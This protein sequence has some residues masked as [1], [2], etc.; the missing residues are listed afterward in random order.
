MTRGLIVLL[1]LFGSE[2]CA[3][4]LTERF[5]PP[6]G[7]A[8]LPLAT[9][10]FG[11]WLRNVPLLEDSARVLLYNGHPKTRQDVHAAVLDIS[12]GERDLQQCADAVI[13]L[14]AEYLFM[15]GR[16]NEIAFNFTS[17]AR[18]RWSDWKTGQRPVVKGNQVTWRQ[19]GLVDSSAAAFHDYLQMVFTFAGSASLEK[20]LEQVSP[21]DIRPGDVFIQG[22]YP[23]HTV[24]VMD[25][26]SDNAGQHKMMLAQSYMPAQS[27]HILRNPFDAATV[28]YD[29]RESG[30]LPTPEWRF[31]FED[32]RRFP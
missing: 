7:F 28:W 22:G 20:E 4:T 1:L 30:E 10:S 5:G 13:R 11:T 21:L 2:L 17:G 16:E 15:A 3:E 27:I 26:V 29:V 9:E 25:V 6:A 12:V 24:I 14:R 8:R 18:C 32:L 23:G 31:R 19:T